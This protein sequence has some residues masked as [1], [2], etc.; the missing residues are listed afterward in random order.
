MDD[1]T[2]LSSST[3]GFVCQHL[4]YDLPID[5]SL[6]VENLLDPAHIPFAHEGTIGKRE[7]A[8]PMEMKMTVTPRGVRGQV[9]E[10]YFNQFDAPCTVVL[11]TP[12]VPGKMDMW[13]FVACTPI[14][15]N[16]MRLVY[17]AYRNFATWI[18]YIPPLAAYFNSFSNKIIFQDYALLAGQQQRILEGA[19]PW[20]ASV[21]VDSL[22]LAYRRW[23]KKTYGDLTAEGPWWRGWNGEVDIEELGKT[24]SWGFDCGGCSTPVLP[25]HPY[26]PIPMQHWKLPSS[27]GLPMWAVLLIGILVAVVARLA[28]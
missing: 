16:R 19:P 4:C 24:A 13:Q 23:W 14:G 20:N 12:P 3:S 2:L 8:T 22:P 9:K 10:G 11:H 17:R 25:D 26:N 6:M 1:G 15:H 5:H 28:W 21:Q 18:D 27:I 7:N